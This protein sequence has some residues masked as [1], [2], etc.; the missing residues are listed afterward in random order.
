[1]IERL[2]PA[3]AATALVA[4]ALAGCGS[5]S[6]SDTKRTA[7]EQLLVSDAIERAVMKIDLAPLAGRK[8]FL[9]TTVLANVEDKDYLASVV[10]QH[11]L[12]SGCILAAKRDD[13]EIIVESRAGALGTD[14]NSIMLGMPAT[15]VEFAGNGTSIPEL[16]LVKRGDQRAV[17]KISLFAYYRATGTPVWQSNAEHIASHHRDRWFFGAG[18]FQDGRIHDRM[19]FAGEKLAAPWAKTIPDDEDVAATFDLTRQRTF[20]TE[21][22]AATGPAA[23]ADR[24]PVD[25]PPVR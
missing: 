24:R 17:A 12:G 21:P 15:S 7:I 5:T 23:T 18:P 1:M 10:R 6:G 13:A 19:E 16:A 8:V 20:T 2:P 3:L 11:V 4:V 22:T 9:D 25:L 14:R